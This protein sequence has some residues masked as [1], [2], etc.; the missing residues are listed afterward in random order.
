[1]KSISDLRSTISAMGS[2]QMKGDYATPHAVLKDLVNDPVLQDHPADLLEALVLLASSTLD[3]LDARAF[4]SRARALA[5]TL[6]PAAPHHSQRIPQLRELLLRIESSLHSATTR[7][8]AVTPRLPVANLQATIDFYSRHLGFPPTLLWPEHDP[9]F[10]LLHRDGVTLGFFTPTEHQ[11]GPIGYAELHLDITGLSD[12][13]DRLK[14]SLSF[15][16]GPEIYSYGRRECAFMDP[17]GYLVIL[18]EST[19]EPPTSSEP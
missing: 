2:A 9:T 4:A 3:P 1:M 16:W 6:D 17:S 12:L 13:H 14:Q 19:S 7:F 8:H 15:A 11:T 5:D 10:V 18:S